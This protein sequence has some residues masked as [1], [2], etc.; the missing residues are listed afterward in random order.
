MKKVSIFLVAL[1]LLCASHLFADGGF[2]ALKNGVRMFKP[3]QRAM[4]AWSGSK[5]ILLLSTD[6][7]ASEATQVLE[8]VPLPSEPKVTK[9]DVET[10][11][12]PPPLSIVK[13]TNL[14]SRE[15]AREPDRRPAVLQGKS[16]FIKK[17]A[18][19]ISQSPTF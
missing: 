6:M 4:I 16:L 5:E 7:R 17:S 18:P 12:E 10:F 1:L 8:V 13:F 19:T 14:L 2:I 3:N 11:E 15:A 9:G